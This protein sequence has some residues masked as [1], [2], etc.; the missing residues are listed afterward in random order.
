MALDA[1]GDKIPS[2]ILKQTHKVKVDHSHYT[3]I[4]LSEPF[5]LISCQG[6]LQDL[7]MEHDRELTTDLNQS[8][9][10]STLPD[11]NPS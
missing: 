8:H 7:A 10:R 4:V 9:P 5:Y 2:D 1:N 6:H 3:I 11:A